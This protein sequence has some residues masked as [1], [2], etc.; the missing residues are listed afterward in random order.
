[1]GCSRPQTAIKSSA[2]RTGEYEQLSAR[3]K[4]EVSHLMEHSSTQPRRI[5]SLETS[6]RIGSVAVGDAQGVV[7]AGRLS[8]PMT[9]AR[10]LLPLVDR[11]LNEQGWP[12]ASLTEVF[13]SIGP[14]SFTGLRIG[15]TI[16]R[17]LAW[18]TGASIV[19]VPTMDVLARNAL[20]LPEPPANVAILID[21]KR[22]QAYS[23][24][25]RLEGDRYACVHPA[26]LAEPASFLA[27]C[28]KPLA[29][30]GEG[31]PQHREAIEAAGA[32]ILD[33]SLWSGQAEHVDAIGR[34]LAAAGSYTPAEQ[35]IPHYI[36][37]PEMEERWEARQRAAEEQKPQ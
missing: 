36:R 31:V 16:A 6:G 26:C 4:H 15:V 23:A 14:G 21:A 28:D 17:T 18:S 33:E 5:L 27:R 24:A 37:R 35:L 19:A 8:G 12:A 30:L 2:H 34:E 11:L 10:E 9:H 13:V 1:M 20:S 32:T 7:G 3:F 25:Y 29:V 22:K